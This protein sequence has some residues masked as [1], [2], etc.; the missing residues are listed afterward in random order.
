MPVFGP[1]NFPVRTGPTSPTYAYP[2][3][4]TPDP[5]KIFRPP[6]FIRRVPFPSVADFQFPNIALFGPAGPVAPDLTKLFR[7]PL[8]TR[9]SLAVHPLDPPLPSLLTTTLTAVAVPFSPELFADRPAT[10]PRPQDFLPPNIPLLAAAQLQVPIVGEVLDETVPRPPSHQLDFQFPNL[11]ILT[12]A[13]LRVRPVGGVLD[14]SKPAVLTRPFDIQPTNI[15]ALA[16]AQAQVHPVGEATTEAV[17]VLTLPRDFLFPNLLTI[18]PVAAAPFANRYFEFPAPVVRAQDAPLPNLVISAAPVQAPLFSEIIYERPATQWRAQ[19]FLAPNIVV[20]IRPITGLTFD[21][22]SAALPP[23]D[24]LLPNIPVL[25]AA[26]LQ[27]P[28]VGEAIDEIVPQIGPRQLDQPFPN[29]AG[30]VAK[31]RPLFVPIFDRPVAALPPV[32]TLFPNLLT[33]TL[34]I[35]VGQPFSPEVFSDRP[36]PQQRVQEFAPP[37]IPAL[38]EAQRQVPPVGEVLDE[39][40]PQ[41]PP[42]Q[43]DFAFPNFPLTISGAPVK[44][45]GAILDEL[46]ARIDPRQLDFQFPNIPVLAAAQQA[47]HPVGSALDETVPAPQPPRVA[48]QAPNLNLPVVVAKPVGIALTDARPAPQL[49]RPDFA[50][51]NVAVFVAQVRPFTDLFFDRPVAVSLPVDAPLPNLLT[52][53]LTVVVVGKPS[54]NPIFDRPSSSVQQLDF[55]F[56]NLVVGGPVAPVLTALFREPLFTWRSP[57]VN[58]GDPPLPNLLTTTLTVVVTGNPFFNPIFDR[59][60]LAPPNPDFLFPNLLTTTLTLAPSAANWGQEPEAPPNRPDFAFPNLLIT[61]F[62]LVPGIPFRPNPFLFTDRP[63]P[64]APSWDHPPANFLVLRPPG[65][66]PVIPPTGGGG[67]LRYRWR[68]CDFTDREWF[69]AFCEEFYRLKALRSPELRR[70]QLADLEQALDLAI[71]RA[72]G[73]GG[74]PEWAI[75]IRAA[76]GMLQDELGSSE[77]YDRIEAGLMRLALELDDEEAFLLLGS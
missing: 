40:V 9:Q 31:V 52:T 18:Q 26:Q 19:D 59:R 30:L 75:D 7:P 37:N 69:K 14:E 67:E 33:T 15:P 54:F 6:L 57:A 62:S 45:A 51:P 48:F 8:F 68:W 74:E 76:G 2:S 71:E 4:G 5:T 50:F 46:R 20:T 27:V 42:H 47:V 38:A 53:T 70:R 11:P 34:A 12:A 49:Q 36:T 56:P 64:L 72:A 28:P 41:P 61:T 44:P 63:L 13:Q 3:A 23:R 1:N 32:D 66:P 65:I 29:V 21:R 58:R 24:Q 16:A 60:P 25:A 73:G 22:P 77:G 35:A 43:L 55:Q 17:P 39:T 10:Q